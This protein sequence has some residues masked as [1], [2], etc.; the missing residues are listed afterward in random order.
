MR[1][2][3][4]SLKWEKA[5]LFQSYACEEQ[6]TTNREDHLSLNISLKIIFFLKKEQLS[7][8]Q[9]FSQK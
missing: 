2:S 4:L 1:N 3:A 7:E 6:N 5:V 8:K 9:A